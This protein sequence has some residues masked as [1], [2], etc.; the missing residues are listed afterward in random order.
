MM[1]VLGASLGRIGLWVMF[2]GPLTALGIVEGYW[3]AD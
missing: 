1:F 2:L 3:F